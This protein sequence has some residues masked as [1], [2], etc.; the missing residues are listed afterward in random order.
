MNEPYLKAC[1]TSATPM[2]PQISIV[3]TILLS[4]VGSFLSHTSRLSG[5][6]SSCSRQ[7]PKR[8]YGLR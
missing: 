5:S 2:P 6:L 1:T 4:V 7:L 8:I 3:V